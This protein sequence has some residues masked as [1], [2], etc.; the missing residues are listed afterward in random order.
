M[1]KHGVNMFAAVKA[2]LSQLIPGFPISMRPPLEDATKEQVEALSK[3]Q[4]L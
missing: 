4:Q 1:E 2:G 3:V